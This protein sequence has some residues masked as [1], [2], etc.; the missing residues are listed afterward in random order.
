M[1][2]FEME[3]VAWIICLEIHDI[4]GL[5]IYVPKIILSKSPAP[6][7]AEEKERIR[8]VTVTDLALNNYKGFSVIHRFTPDVNGQD[9]FVTS[10]CVLLLCCVCIYQ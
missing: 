6:C 10:P 9:V 7:A 2:D 5:K 8:T 3:D 4:L 1:K